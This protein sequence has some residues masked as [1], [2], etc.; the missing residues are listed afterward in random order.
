V[1]L[2][3]LRVAEAFECDELYKV[4]TMDRVALEFDELVGGHELGKGQ[5]APSFIRPEKITCPF[6]IR[7]LHA[8]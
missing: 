7:R 4:S 8:T 5:N 1:Q 6:S 2:F 3:E